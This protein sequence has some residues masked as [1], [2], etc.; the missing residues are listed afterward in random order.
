MDKRARN[1]VETHRGARAMIG[2]RIG[3]RFHR[4]NAR[5]GIVGEGN[6]EPLAIGPGDER[7]FRPA[8]R[9]E[10]ASLDRFAAGRAQRRQ[11]KIER[12]ARQRAHRIRSAS[13]AQGQ[14]NAHRHRHAA[15]L[16]RRDEIVIAGALQGKT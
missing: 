1:V 9:T 11:S 7:E 6:A 5:A 12:R 15:M 2:R 4:Q 16:A 3:D 13:D 8:G 14:S 10:A